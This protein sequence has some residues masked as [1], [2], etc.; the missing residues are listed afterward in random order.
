MENLF[1][2]Y[3]YFAKQR[4]YKKM[5]KSKIIMTA[6]LMLMTVSLAMPT[7]KASAAVTFYYAPGHQANNVHKSV[8]ASGGTWQY[9]YNYVPYTNQSVATGS[10][11]N[12]YHGSRRHESTVTLSQT[13]TGWARAGAR[14]WS[15]KSI[16]V[17]PWQYAHWF[18]NFY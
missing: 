15:S 10:Y 2:G 18:Y 4:G 5:K 13:A 9:G 1:L 8:G 16:K 11:S 6:V 7:T 3:S 12:Y 17:L 14:T